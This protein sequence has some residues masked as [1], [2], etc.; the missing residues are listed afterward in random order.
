MPV[1]QL[2]HLIIKNVTF[3]PDKLHAFKISLVYLLLMFVIK[4][5]VSFINQLYT[6]FIRNFFL[7]YFV[8][9]KYFKQV[10]RNGSLKKANQKIL[11]R[12]CVSMSGSKFVPS[13]SLITKADWFQARRSSNFFFLCFPGASAKCNIISPVF[14]HSILVFLTELLQIR[15]NSF[16]LLI[17][18]LKFMIII[19]KYYKENLGIIKI[20]R[21]LTTHMI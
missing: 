18:F 8:Y 12:F 2:F 11:L 16:F 17:Y 14:A 13:N 20:K 9:L 4:S 6:S 10:L 15:N 1:N 21:A 5:H 7:F 3:K 19:K